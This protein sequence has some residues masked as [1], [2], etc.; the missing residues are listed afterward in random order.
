MPKIATSRFGR[1]QRLGGFARVEC[2]RES[3]NVRQRAETRE[4][5]RVLSARVHVMSIFR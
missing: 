3:K 1:A 5:L 2:A 4:N